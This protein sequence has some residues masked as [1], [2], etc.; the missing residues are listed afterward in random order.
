MTRAR[1]L[2]NAVAMVLGV[3][4][5]GCGG[6]AE[7]PASPPA[8]AERVAASASVAP[9]RAPTM[10]RAAA[11][12]AGAPPAGAPQEASPAGTPSAPGCR[13]SDENHDW[14]ATEAL[15]RRLEGLLPKFSPGAEP[16][17]C[18]TDVWAAS[19][20]ASASLESALHEDFRMAEEARR[21]EWLS[22]LPRAA[23][24]FRAFVPG[25]SRAEV[26]GALVTFDVEPALLTA[27]DAQR[28]TEVAAPQHCVVLAAELHGNETELF[29]GEPGARAERPLFTVSIP[30]PEVRQRLGALAIGDVVRFGGYLSL[31]GDIPRGGSEVQLWHFGDVEASAVEV[32]ARGT[33][34]PR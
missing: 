15:L 31:V 34:C 13:G 6:G 21:S 17:R 27:V 16:A 29:C 23:V 8:A 25:V 33:C 2:N 14:E 24:W 32:V 10:E 30:N 7:A 3:A 12:P 5:W 4:Y 18:M 28:V 20:P 11:P 9:T 22:G 26:R 1:R 19:D